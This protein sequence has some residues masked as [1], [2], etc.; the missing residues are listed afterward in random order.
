MLETHFASKITE[1]RQNFG[2]STLPACAEHLHF[3]L[4]GGI[5]RASRPPVT[6]AQTAWEDTDKVSLQYHGTS[7]DKPGPEQHSPLDRL[8]S[9]RRK[10][11]N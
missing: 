7:T 2:P 1:K 3:M 6:R 10:K 4:T 9:T 11:R 5:R 8:T